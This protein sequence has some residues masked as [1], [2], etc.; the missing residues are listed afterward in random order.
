M[1]AARRCGRH[2]RGHEQ[3]AKET[4]VHADDL[5]DAVRFTRLYRSFRHVR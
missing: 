5:P 1:A 2:S 4:P 3:K